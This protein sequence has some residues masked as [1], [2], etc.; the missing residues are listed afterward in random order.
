MLRYT[1]YSQ[2]VLHAFQ[3][4]YEKKAKRAGM[5]V[6]YNPDV[7]VL[8][9]VRVLLRLFYESTAILFHENI[10][11]ELTGAFY[12]IRF[13]ERGLYQIDSPLHVTIL[14]AIQLSTNTVSYAFASKT[15]RAGLS[16]F[17]FLTTI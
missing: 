10:Q 16:I 7:G 17:C 14:D 12:R 2:T 13:D 11:G 4:V 6:V 5:P 3:I 8:P 1:E 9:A 15:R